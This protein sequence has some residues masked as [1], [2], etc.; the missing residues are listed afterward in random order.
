[1]H[2]Q[3]N[4]FRY[5]NLAVANGAE[6]SVMAEVNQIWKR[7]SPYEAF[8][9]QWYTDYLDQRHSHNEDINFMLLLVGLALSIACLG[10]LGMVTYNTSL[11]IKEV[12]IRKVMGA[13]VRQLVWLLSWDFIRLLLISGAIAFPVGTL[14]GY[15]FLMSFAYHVSIGIETLGSCLGILLLLGGVTIGW[16]TYRAAQ[17]NPAS[18]LRAE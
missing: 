14:L 13:Q 10:L 3:P 12:G 9:G 16:R 15:A 11:R 6:E 8:T 5:L 17:T 7:L 18:S 2:Y 1:V 4:R